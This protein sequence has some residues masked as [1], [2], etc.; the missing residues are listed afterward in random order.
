MDGRKSNDGRDYF[1]TD[2]NDL[3]YED[4][5]DTNRDLYEADHTFEQNQTNQYMLDT[6][7]VLKD[8]HEMED[9]QLTDRLSVLDNHERL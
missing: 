5:G 1:E 8:Q 4:M 2:P 6:D 7:K 3:S 9:Y